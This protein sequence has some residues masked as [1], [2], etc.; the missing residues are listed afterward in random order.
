MM[1][2]PN[3][4]NLGLA[5]LV[6]IVAGF[7]SPALA[8]DQPATPS[9][10]VTQPPDFKIGIGDA[11]SVM[12]WREPEASADA[13]VRPDGKISLPLIG[14]IQAAGMSTE[15]LNT[16]ITSK[17]QNGQIL[18]NPTVT[19]VVTQINSLKVFISGEVNAPGAYPL[20]QPTTIVQLI[21]LANGFTTY[22]DKG[23]V[24]VIRQPVNPG[25]PPQRI[26]VNF[27]DIFDGKNLER[28]VIYLMPG[29]T[30]LVRE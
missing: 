19:V 18:A 21:G 13:V 16:E 29:D 25:D 26:R 8:Q 10:G 6:A 9:A 12:V 14:E 4:R 30:I 11:L 1:W 17:L 3:V 2:I 24:I 15:Q 5:A 7:G 27:D 20:L 23:E 28:N 22:A